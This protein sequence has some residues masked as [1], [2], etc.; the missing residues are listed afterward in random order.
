MSASYTHHLIAS[1]VFSVLPAPLHAAVEPYL[2]L[3]FFGAQGADFCFFCPLTDGVKKPINFGSY[4]HRYGG[5]SAFNVCKLFSARD[6][7]LFSY[8][9][10][11]ITHYAADVAFHPFVYAT[12]G[13]SPLRHSRVERAIDL[14]LQKNL[15]QEDVHKK[16]YGKKPCENERQTLFLLYAAFAA[17]NRLPVLKKSAFFRSFSLFNA[18]L[19]RSSAVLSAKNTRLINALSNK[20]NAEW[21]NPAATSLKS[22]DGALE[23]F[24]KSVK[25]ALSAIEEFSFAVKNKTALSFAV[26]GKN[27]LSGL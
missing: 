4:L 9:L 7:A 21:A 17:V 6:E 1:R 13:K 12:A 23:L 18:Y 15:S 25:N 5:F 10:G 22:R 26:F 20:G 3:Y 19:P 2:S 8:S 14:F 11:Y 24:E 16:F 27:Y